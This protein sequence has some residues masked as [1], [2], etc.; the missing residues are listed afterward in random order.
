MNES[1]LAELKRRKA[2]LVIGMIGYMSASDAGYTEVD[3][4][5][6]ESILEEFTANLQKLRQDADE[7]E[8]LRCV[9]DI[10]LKLNKLND[11]TGGCLIET[12]Q[13]EDLWSYID[14]AARKSG[15][16]TPGDITEEWRHW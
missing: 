15:L 9:R 11:K 1:D 10:V 14:Y 13:R 3:V 5:K 4:E 12:D 6:C 7:P 2:K 8:I 16:K